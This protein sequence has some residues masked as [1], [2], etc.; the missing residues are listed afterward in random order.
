MRHLSHILVVA[1]LAGANAA[2]PS[3]LHHLSELQALGQAGAAQ[4]VAI[5]VVAIVTVY[6]PSLYQFYV[7]EGDAGVYVGVTNA[8]AW[9]VQA[10]DRVRIRGKSQQGGYSPIIV[11][12]SIV[13]IDSPG[14]PA[15]VRLS[16]WS[17]IHN[18]DRLDNI[19]VEVV[20]TVVSVAPL[21]M[22][23]REA[24]FGAH[25]LTL[26]HN[27]ETLQGMLFVPA[28]FDMSALVQSD[29]VIRG[30]VTP[31]RMMH[32]Q[33]HDGWIVIG[34]M[35]DVRILRRHPLDWDKWPNVPLSKLLQ[36]GGPPTPEGYFRTEGTV[37]W[38]DG[39]SAVTIEEGVSSIDVR[40]AWPQ[41]LRQGRRYEV[42]GRLVRG[43]RNFWHIEEAQFR[44]IGPGSVAPIRAALPREI[45]LGELAGELVAS[46]G[47]VI[48]VRE[49]R[50]TCVLRL[51]D[52]EF[53]WEA[54]LPRI[55]G[56]CPTWIVPGSRV[57]VTGRL[58]QRWMDGR[59]F[60]VQTTMLMRSAA[61][62][63]VLS[64]PG[65]WH[66]LP[67]GKLLAALALLALV[68][69]AW[70]W[71]LRHQVRA[72]TSRIA[73][74]NVELEK[75][76]VKAEEASRLKSEFLANMSHEIRTPMNGVMGMTEI[77]LDS[78]LNSQQRTDLLTVKS[79]AESLLT[80]LNDILDFSKIEAGKLTLEPIAFDVRDSIHKIVRSV[81]V[82]A[83][84]KELE[85]LCDFAPDVP[86]FAVGDPTRLRQILVNL[87]GN[88]VK[89]T[90][91]G[92]VG[93]QVS[94]EQATETST[95]L[96]FVVSDTGIGIP[97]E[98]HETIFRA[99][100]QADASTTRRH[101]GTGL[102]LTISARLVALMGG[103]MW[104]ESTPGKG[105]RFHFTAQFGNAPPQPSSQARF[106]AALLAGWPVAI[107]DDN[108]TNR[109]ILADTVTRWGMRA[110]LAANAEDA[111]PMLRS[112][113]RSG[114]PFSLIVSDVQMAD[115]DG[116]ALAERVLGDPELRGTKIVLLASGGQRGDAARCREIG[117]AAYLTK[118]VSAS[119]LWAAVASVLGADSKADR[120][121][122]PIARHA[123]RENLPGL[124]ILVAEDNPVNQQLIR[125]L[126]EKHHHEVVIVEDGQKAVAAVERERF[127]LV[128]MDVQMPE[129]DGL[130]ATAAI[131]DL[132]KT[133]GDHRWIVAMTAHAMNG[134]RERCLAAGMDG[135]VAKPIRPNELTELLDL[136]RAGSDAIAKQPGPVP[137]S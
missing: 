62:V 5:D 25:E 123:L 135:Y 61:D 48:D 87:L 131:R 12:D 118:P 7:Q 3:L 126:L 6:K 86:A 54:E 39:V 109:R 134:D 56:D 107:V 71:Q 74:Q 44:E 95:P 24:E 105:S 104:L 119:E 70:I 73:E 112:A 114:S 113:A 15:P 9:K 111:L 92:E 46:P 32:K 22:D 124:H 37:T 85:L 110:A 10:G 53:S 98:K 57:E 115:M 93:V 76:K 103:R 89:F 81:G 84:Q 83:Q 50:G 36:L 19:I 13:R 101:G 91:R 80:V 30:L 18:T 108:A 75:E 94:V 27:G 38:F 82:L 1:A 130:E 28:G 26:A 47:T 69:L 40:R 35:N 127:D 42:L 77:L 68:A 52:L 14:L 116:F 65:L 120:T 122:P 8:S 117:V 51:E 79:S 125:R 96:H 45:A 99:F 49:A 66:R 78:E 58:Q 106:D 21:Y 11:P 133:S 63:R 121:Q 100:T 17:S 33:R 43:E 129:M 34:S 136:V 2:A 55:L 41:S 29:V 137:G 90:E 23:G 60:P 97:A 31:S 132:E 67:L 4:G 16:S 59:Q 72:Q 102:G 128:L 88:A 20:G 64:Q